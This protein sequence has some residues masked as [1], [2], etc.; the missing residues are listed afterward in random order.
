MVHKHPLLGR[1]RHWL[2]KINRKDQQCC[3]DRQKP[4]YC[5][6]DISHQVQRHGHLSASLGSVNLSLTLG[7]FSSNLHLKCQREWGPES[8]DWS[9]QNLALVSKCYS[10]VISSSRQTDHSNNDRCKN[11]L[12]YFENA[13]RKFCSLRVYSAVPQQNAMTD[14]IMT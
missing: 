8:T 9:L 13:L 11:F 10:V 4:Q 6:G 14:K 7:A 5:L 3:S 1:K 2:P 12:R